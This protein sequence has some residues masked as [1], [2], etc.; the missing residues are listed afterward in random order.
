MSEYVLD[1]L[2]ILSQVGAPIIFGMLLFYGVTT[3][4]RRRHDAVPRADADPAMPKPGASAQRKRH[5]NGKTA[6]PQRRPDDFVKHRIGT[7]G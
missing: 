4:E 5:E 7:S 2:L 1:I 3:S 6:T